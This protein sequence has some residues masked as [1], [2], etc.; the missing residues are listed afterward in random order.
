M[1]CL[2]QRW[3]TSSLSIVRAGKRSARD[4][5]V[6]LAWTRARDVLHITHGD[7]QSPLQHLERY[8]P[9]QLRGQDGTLRDSNDPVPFVRIPDLQQRDWEETDVIR[10]SDG[11]DMRF[12]IKVS[13]HLD[14]LSF[15][16]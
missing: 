11:S 7:L 2:F 14:P 3:L 5:P 13:S 6:A 10:G 12:K 8:H 9:Y 4:R 1:S 16:A 15:L